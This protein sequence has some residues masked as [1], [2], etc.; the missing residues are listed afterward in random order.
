MEKHAYDEDSNIM[1]AEI[2][3][4]IL[5]N[6]GMSYADLVEKVQKCF[7]NDP[8][9][10]RGALKERMHTK[11]GKDW[12]EKIEIALELPKNTLVNIK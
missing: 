10:N 12:C 3:K 11:L 1:R 7:P 6:R 5:Q 2:L 4:K 8:T 9:L